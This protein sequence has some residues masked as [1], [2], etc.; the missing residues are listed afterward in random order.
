MVEVV[1]YLSKGTDGKG[2]K[3]GNGGGNDG[4]GGKDAKGGKDGKGGKDAAAGPATAATQA[5]LINDLQTLVEEQ[6]VNIEQLQNKRFES[7]LVIME[8]QN[9]MNELKNFI[10]TLMQSTKI[11]DDASTSALSGGTTPS[12]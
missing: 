2:G 12:A 10:K 8:L 6:N 5:D 7:D 4:K 1:C 11:T 9:D 3:D